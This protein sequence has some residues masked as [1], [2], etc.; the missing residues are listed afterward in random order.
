MELAVAVMTSLSL[1]VPDIVAPLCSNVIV[2]LK[3][4]GLW[5][6]L[7]Q[8]AVFDRLQVPATSPPEPELDLLQLTNPMAQ[9]RCGGKPSRST[10]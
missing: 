2:S 3:V 9:S 4:A 8:V 7:A 6:G 10:R 5:A 1:S